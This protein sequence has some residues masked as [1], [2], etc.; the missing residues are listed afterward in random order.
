[1]DTLP[2]GDL[3]H[4]DPQLDLFEDSPESDPVLVHRGLHPPLP[5]S[6]RVLVWGFGL[7]RQ[8]RRLGIAALPCRVLPPLKGELLLGIALRLEARPGRYSWEEKQKIL[9]FAAAR[10]EA[11]ESVDLGT[12][13]P[14][15]EGRTDPRFEARITRFAGLPPG[16]RRAVAAGELDLKAAE[17]AAELPAQLLPLLAGSPLSFSQRRQFLLQLREVARRERLAPPDLSALAARLLQGR[18]PLQAL[19]S[20]RFPALTALTERFAALA[21][22]L[23]K[24]SGVRID[25]PPYFEGGDFAV[26]FRFSSPENLR[27]KLRALQSVAEHSDELFALLR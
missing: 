8:A 16:A 22:S 14:W 17:L 1:M 6:G 20:L 7:Y 12:L 15:I 2:V 5:V 10:R 25:P 19:A 4:L 9:R 3:E 21:R 13:S 11:G 26:G 24:G 18:D 27:R 23:W